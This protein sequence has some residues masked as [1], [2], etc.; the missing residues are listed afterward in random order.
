MKSSK[1]VCHCKT[2][3]IVLS[4]IIRLLLWSPDITRLALEAGEVAEQPDINVYL[5]DPRTE[6]SMLSQSRFTFRIFDRVCTT[7][8]AFKVYFDNI[9][10][11]EP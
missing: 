1:Y 7:T 9:S 11:L 2:C 8:D 6:N 5:Q 3:V 4:V 10:F